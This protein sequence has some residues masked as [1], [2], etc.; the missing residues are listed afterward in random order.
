LADEAAELE[1]AAAVGEEEVTNAEQTKK[2][3]R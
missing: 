1:L 3:R 2:T